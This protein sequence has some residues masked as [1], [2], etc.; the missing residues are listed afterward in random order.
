MEEQMPDYSKGSVSIFETKPF[1][2]WVKAKGYRWPP[3]RLNE[4]DLM[5]SEF[6]R[7]GFAAHSQSETGEKS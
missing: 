5:Y 2:D 1:Q 6:M 7:D 3:V 4:R